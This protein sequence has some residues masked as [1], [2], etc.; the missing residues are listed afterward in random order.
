MKTS[1]II[2]PAFF[3]PFC[4]VIFSCL[5]NAAAGTGAASERRLSDYMPPLKN[6]AYNT[7]V[8]ILDSGVPGMNV[9]VIGG[10]HGGERAGII[11]AGL[12]VRHALPKRGCMFVIPR[13]NKSSGRLVSE[14]ARGGNGEELYFPPGSVRA[15]PGYEGR[16]INRAYP[17]SAEIDA[18]PAQKIAFAVMNILTTEGIDLAIDLHE[19]GISS[20][21][22]WHII[23]N[24]KNAAVAASAVLDLE[25]KNIPMNMDVSPEEMRGL[26]HKEWGDR[27]GAGA[28]LIETSEQA[29]LWKRTAVHL[30][31]I[32]SLIA[33]TGA[34]KGK[35]F[36]YGGVP[37]YAEMERD[38]REGGALLSGAL[39]FLPE[40]NK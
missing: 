39:S 16:N 31:T 27:T 26:S 3:L 24:P 20:K 18:G 30:E 7:E 32:A 33:C 21:L 11:A 9:L 6:S 13:L 10:T 23:A 4:A 17:G 19:T 14:P 22:A 28:F 37:D 12:L 15:L 36:V 38:N 25:E 40:E 2:S 1:T 34:A 35:L 29:P 5:S 8:Y